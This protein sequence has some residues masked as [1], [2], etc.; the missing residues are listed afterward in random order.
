MLAVD[1]AVLEARNAG[2]DVDDLVGPKVGDLG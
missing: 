1:V 2:V